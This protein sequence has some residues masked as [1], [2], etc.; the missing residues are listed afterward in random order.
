MKLDAHHGAR[1]HGLAKRRGQIV[2]AVA[3]KRL[4][5]ED[6]RRLD[7]IFKALDEL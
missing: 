1:W 6:H 5:A 2:R 4:M 3:T 7:R